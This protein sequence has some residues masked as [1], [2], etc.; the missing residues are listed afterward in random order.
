MARFRVRRLGV[1]VLITDWRRRDN[2]SARVEGDDTNRHLVFLGSKEYFPLFVSLTDFW[3]SPDPAQSVRKKCGNPPPN[4]Y[5]RAQPDSR[6]TASVPECA[7]SRP[8]SL[9]GILRGHTR[10][11]R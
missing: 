7:I 5:V 10:R 6:E 3:L 9:L 11:S 4:S 8:L 1:N 2:A